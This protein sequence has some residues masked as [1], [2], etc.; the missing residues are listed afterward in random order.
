MIIF[1]TRMYVQL[2]DAVSASKGI[3]SINASK[4]GMACLV[5]F[6]TAKRLHV[7]FLGMG[8]INDSKKEG[9]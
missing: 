3:S 9:R 8:Q 6:L 5:G 2:V 4:S 7:I 1:T